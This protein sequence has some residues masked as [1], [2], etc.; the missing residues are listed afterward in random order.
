MPDIEVQTVFK[1]SAQCRFR[2]AGARGL[3]IEL[4]DPQREEEPDLFMIDRLHVVKLVAWLLDNCGIDP[5]VE[6][7]ATAW[8]IRLATILS[9]RGDTGRVA[10]QLGV[11]SITVS[12]YR[13]HLAVPRQDVAERMCAL[14][15]WPPEVVALELRAARRELWNER[16]MRK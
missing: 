11:P 8:R 7:A 14:F 2:W 3:I 1:A 13:R 15:G 4:P 10:E 5:A 6:L 12:R 16:N 9:R